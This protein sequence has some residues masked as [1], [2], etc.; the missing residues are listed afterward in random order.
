M[1]SLIIFVALVGT[2]SVFALEWEEKA[3]G[4]AAN[5]TLRVSL[6]V[7]ERVKGVVLLKKLE[8][9]R[10]S[11]H[12]ATFFDRSQ[13]LPISRP[14]QA[15]TEGYEVFRVWFLAAVTKY[16]LP[17]AC[18]ETLSV[19]LTT[20]KKES[21]VGSVCADR[22]TGDEHRWL[23]RWLEKWEPETARA[24]KSTRGKRVPQSS[25]R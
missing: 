9:E 2:F 15:F 25:K 16:G 20:D 1:K 14:Y 3:L 17:L 23:A 21:F 8:G 5:H 18:T 7:N 4:R 11:Y 10:A 6:A 13:E 22:F 12:S 24:S 19:R